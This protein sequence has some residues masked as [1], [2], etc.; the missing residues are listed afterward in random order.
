MSSRA[1]ILL[2]L[3]AVGLGGALLFSGARPPP[4]EAAPPSESQITRH[5]FLDDLDLDAPGTRHAVLLH[6]LATGAGLRAVTDQDVIR[7]A[8]GK[9]FYTDDP[10]QAAKH[11]LLSVVFLSPPTGPV[12]TPFVTIIR[13]K[14]AVETYRCYEAYCS[15]RYETD[16]PHTHDLSGLLDASV[17]VAL[18]TKQ[19]AHHEQ[20]RAAHF[21]ALRNP[22]IVMIEPPHLPAP[23]T[24]VYPRRLRLT[25]PAQLIDADAQTGEPIIPFDESLFEARFAAAFAYA[26]P[27]TEAY[28]LGPMRFDMFYPPAQGWPVVSDRFDTSYIHDDRENLI[29]LDRIAVVEPSLVID[30]IPDMA[31]QLQTPDA[32]ADMPAFSL[33]PKDLS[34]RLDRL[35]EELLGEPCPGCLQIELPVQTGEGIKVEQRDPVSYKLHYYEVVADEPAAQQ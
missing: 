7:A 23:S 32:F 12:M 8:Q 24:I 6:D 21:R 9:A 2:L 26:Y 33:K 30:L 22:A 35:A 29:G 34:T 16:T 4:Q 3:A 27:D 15:Q 1:L 13:D 20:A 11:V 18:V 28:R 17:P 10:S 25:L 31:E 14:N 19:F 5:A